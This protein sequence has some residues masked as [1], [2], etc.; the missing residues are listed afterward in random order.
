MQS[1]SRCST[2][3]L[4]GTKN[5][6]NMKIKEIRQEKDRFNDI[7]TVTLEPNWFEKLFGVKEKEVKYKDTGN[8]F[9][10]GDGH[11]Y[12]DQNGEQLHNHSTIGEEIDKFRRRW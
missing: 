5:Y 9:V 2:A 4:G 7:F 8:T 12:V 11:V 10:F 1:Y 3:T 6:K